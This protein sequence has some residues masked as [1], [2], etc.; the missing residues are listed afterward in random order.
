[1][2]ISPI[3]TDRFTFGIL[4]T[5]VAV[6]LIWTG[7]PLLNQGLASR[8]FKDYL[9]QWEVSIRA[10]SAQQGRWPVFSGSNHVSYMD[11]VVRNM[12]G[13]GVPLPNSNTNVTYR[14]HIDKFGSG[15]EDIFIL[16]FHDRL[17]LYGLSDN[18][19]N[20]LDKTIDNHQDLMHGQVRGY[21]GKN[22]K[23]FIGMW[24]I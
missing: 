15:D 5:M 18:S 1:M 11:S 19:L 10:H 3:A 21:L 17:M 20:R 14:Y 22:G 8:F 12:A 13:D 7:F 4:Y 16:C 6:I 23:T 9:L 24:R 2:A